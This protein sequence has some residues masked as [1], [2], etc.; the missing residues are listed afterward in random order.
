MNSIP[1]YISILRIILSIILL[2]LEPLSI[3]F[4]IIY[5]TCGISDVLD[6]YI[7]RKTN[8]T[9][10]LGEKLDSIADLVLVITLIFIFYPI[11]NLTIEAIIWISIIGSIRIISIIIIFIKYKMFGIIHTYGNKLTGIILLSF[12]PLLKIIES[13]ILIYIICIVASISAIEELLINII[14]NNLEINRKSI[15]IK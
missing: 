1:N 12:V 11:I 13:D 5:I 3:E 6:G 9:S 7:A 14:S 8:S 2:I 10:K 4:Y 15:L